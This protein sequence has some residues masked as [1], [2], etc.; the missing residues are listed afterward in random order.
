[1]G[2]PA[3][4]PQLQKYRAA[5]AVNLIGHQTPALPLGIRVDTGGN[6]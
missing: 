3:D 4:V 5:I 6:Q 2:H 1:M